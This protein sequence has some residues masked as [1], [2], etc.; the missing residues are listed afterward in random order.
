LAQASVDVFS[1]HEFYICE[2]RY[3]GYLGHIFYWRTKDKKEIDYAEACLL[4][5]ANRH[6]MDLVPVIKIPGS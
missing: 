4:Y 5:Q 3:T 1:I 6:K 2:K